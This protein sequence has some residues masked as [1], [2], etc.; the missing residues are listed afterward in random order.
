V[1][2]RRKFEHFYYISIEV[3]LRSLTL[4]GEETRVWADSAYSGQKR[5]LSECSPMAKDHTQKK[6]S[7]N[8]KLT[9]D[10][11]SKNWNKS[12]VRA[13]VEPVFHVIKRQFGFTKV[14]YRGLDKNANWVFMPCALINLVMSKNHLARSI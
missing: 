10:E 7:R 1:I 11:R 12:K 2:N 14:R 6:C 3:D 8:R 9:D 13:K 5:V 4:H